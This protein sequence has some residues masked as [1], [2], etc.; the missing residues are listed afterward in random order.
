MKVK[1]WDDARVCAEAARAREGYTGW[2]QAEISMLLRACIQAPPGDVFVA[3]DFSGVEARANAYSAGDEPA[4]ATFKA[5][6]DAYA[7]LAIRL[8]GCEPWPGFPA[9]AA[10]WREGYEEWKV[11]Y[12][13]P[14]DTSKKAELGCGYGMGPPKFKITAEKGGRMSWHAPG[15]C[16]G[17]DAC[18][19]PLC[20]VIL[21]DERG[22]VFT[23]GAYT[24]V[25]GWRELHPAIVSFW[26]RL[27]SAAVEAVASATSVEVPGCGVSLAFDFVKGDLALVLPSGRPVVYRR[28]GLEASKYGPQ[29]RFTGQ[30]GVSRLYGGLLCENAVQ[31]MCRDL[32][33]NGMLNAEAAGL[34]VCL[35]VHD[36]IVAAVKRARGPR[37][38]EELIAAMCTLPTWAGAMP[39]T[40]EGFVAE[41]YRK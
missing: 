2:N 13:D 25:H 23:H 3:A 20:G 30:Y 6:G 35:T 7:P 5:G 17:E 38:L 4:I 19:D 24:I 16:A 33:T 34:P 11:T 36:E 31:A 39:I 1:K 41:R 32:L 10:P 29:V 15:L 40:A 9:T 37:A 18:T 8:F 27:N 12:F 28:A 22:Q 21:R 26:R 14:R